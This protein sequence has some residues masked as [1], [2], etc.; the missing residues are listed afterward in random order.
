M[1]YQRKKGYIGHPSKSVVAVLLYG[2]QNKLISPLHF[3]KIKNT[4]VIKRWHCE[5]QL[6]LYCS[7]TQCAFCVFIIPKKISISI[8]HDFKKKKIEQV[9]L[10]WQYWNLHILFIMQ[11]DSKKKNIPDK[12][13]IMLYLLKNKRRF[14]PLKK[15]GKKPLVIHLHTR[16][17]QEHV[18]SNE[19]QLWS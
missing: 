9:L 8:N 19:N 15:H 11:G 18:L 17:P 2:R 1:H 10:R 14:P 12:N 5:M 16:T 6:L 4:S 13:K 3:C 7:C